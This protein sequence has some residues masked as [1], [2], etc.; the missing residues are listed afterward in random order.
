MEVHDQ[1]TQLRN[2]AKSNEALENAKPVNSKR[3]L[4]KG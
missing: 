3:P 4:A 2:L 1:A